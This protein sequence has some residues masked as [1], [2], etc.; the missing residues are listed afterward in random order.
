MNVAVVMVV[1][2]TPTGKSVPDSRITQ[3]GQNNSIIAIQY[4]Q[5]KHKTVPLLLSYELPPAAY[6]GKS[7][8]ELFAWKN[9]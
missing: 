7:L 2:E 8:R 4:C 6:R 5:P 9:R 3:L 1:P